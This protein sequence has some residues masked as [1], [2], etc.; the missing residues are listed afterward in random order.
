[1]ISRNKMKWPLVAALALLAVLAGL[2]LGIERGNAPSLVLFAG[3]FHPTIV[4][5]PIAFLILGAGIEILAPTSDAI[6]RL[7]PAVPIILG[8]GALSALAA[9]VLGYLLS[10]DG[11]YDAG[12]LSL[13]MWL[14]FGVFGLSLGIA[15]ASFRMTRS[16]TVYRTVLGALVL[17]VVVTGHLGGSLA[18]GTDYLTY[19]LPESIK[20]VA[21]FGG[22][23]ASGLIVDIDSAR[24]YA[25]LI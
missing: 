22:A 23:P 12:L 21:G 25:D 8:L 20:R 4:H 11:G 13:H 1:M 2:I 17:L 6:G 24:V 19:Y 5:F 15:A 18:R 9:A 16:G 7:R 14:G 3:R 10:L